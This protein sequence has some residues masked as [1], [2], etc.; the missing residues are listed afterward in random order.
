MASRANA[1]TRSRGRSSSQ[2]F[3]EARERVGAL[4]QAKERERD[5]ALGVLQMGDARSQ[6]DARLIANYLWTLR[7]FQYVSFSVRLELARHVIVKEYDAEATGAF[8]ARGDSALAPS[9]DRAPSGPYYTPACRLPAL[10]P[11]CR[12]QCTTRAARSRR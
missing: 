2:W 8:R 7:F 3:R 4:F 6:Q 11:R 12:A 9:P 1:A 10:E 5:A